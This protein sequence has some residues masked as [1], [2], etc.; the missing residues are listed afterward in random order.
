MTDR[1][2][3]FNQQINAV[4]PKQGDVDFIYAQLIVGKRLIQ[5]AST[6]SMKGM[7]SKSRLQNVQIIFPPVDLQR[8]FRNASFGY[9]EAQRRPIQVARLR[10]HS[11]RLASIPS[12]PR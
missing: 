10:G 8:D 11:L 6:S 3:A 7:V 2:V 12:L 4:I 1:P 9:P 5:Q